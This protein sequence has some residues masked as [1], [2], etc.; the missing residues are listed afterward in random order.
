MDQLKTIC[1]TMFAIGTVMTSTVLAADFSVTCASGSAQNILVSGVTDVEVS[2]NAISYMRGRIRGIFWVPQNG[3]RIESDQGFR[4][5][6]VSTVDGETYAA[7]GKSIMVAPYYLSLSRFDSPG[8]HAFG[9]A[10]CKL[11]VL[12]S[13]A[14][15]LTPM[16][17]KSEAIREAGRRWTPPRGATQNHVTVML[18]VHKN[19]RLDQM[20]QGFSYDHLHPWRVDWIMIEKQGAR[21]VITV[22]S[23]YP[24]NDNYYVRG[25]FHWRNQTYYSLAEFNEALRDKS[26][27][28]EMKDLTLMRAMAVA[29][30]QINFDVDFDEEMPLS[31][32]VLRSPEIS[33]YGRDDYA[34]WQMGQITERYRKHFGLPL[35]FPA[36][37]DEP[38]RQAKLLRADGRE[39][40]YKIAHQARAGGWTLPLEEPSWYELRKNNE[41]RASAGSCSSLLG[42]DT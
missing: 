36:Q 17:Q 24:N 25:D 28:I 26:L 11:T 37:V 39:V 3:C 22:S 6:C 23:V 31:A 10:Q 18:N 7:E 34:D 42:K 5:E 15:P 29:R 1:L 9:S 21:D 14:S 2:N 33:G 38:P 35:L 13:A 41:N 4:L 16:L 20:L 8:T 32:S 19:I 30:G 27:K 12:G 40:P